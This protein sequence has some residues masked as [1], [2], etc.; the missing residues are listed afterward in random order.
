MSINDLI[1]VLAAW[2]AAVSIVI[3]LKRLKRLSS[4]S[5]YYGMAIMVREREQVVRLLNRISRPL[6]KVPEKPLAAALISTFVISMFI[7]TPVPLNPLI[8]IPEVAASTLFIQMI[9]GLI[10]MKSL[11]L[12][13]VN[14]FALLAQHLAKAMP[15]EKMVR[16]FL[17][18]QPLVPG[19]TVSL[20]TF[21]MIMISIGIC[22]LVHEIAHG[23]IAARFNVQIRSGGFISALFI[24]FGGFVEI[25]NES[26]KKVSTVRKLSLFSSGIFA[27]VIF[28]YIVVALFLLLTHMTVALGHP[29]GVKVL[30]SEVPG[31]RSGDVIV[32]VNGMPAASIYHFLTYIHDVK[33]AELVIYRPDASTL[34]RDLIAIPENTVIRFLSASDIYVHPLGLHLANTDVYNFLFWLFSMNLT[35]V[36][37]NV[38]PAYPLD[39]GQ[40]LSSLLELTRLSFKARRIL[41]T[42]VSGVVWAMLALTIFFTIRY[43]L[44]VF[45]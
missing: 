27:N 35:L 17:P 43:G 25:D 7:M 29:L 21:V 30:R 44:Y 26:L 12:Y 8:S 34:I 32:L 15:A 22:I 13:L 39:G 45:T 14:N 20:S 28:A 40:I 2:A 11:L 23:V 6:A 31:I 37:L 24:L 36:M 16:E 19:V 42:A 41:M 33:S 3:T 10:F 18:L 5:V 4:L 9:N 38:L 1:V